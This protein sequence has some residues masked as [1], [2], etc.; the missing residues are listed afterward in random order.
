MKKAT[1]VATKAQKA[2][3]NSEKQNQVLSLAEATVMVQKAI[4]GSKCKA[5][6]DS[7]YYV[8]FGVKANGFSV[9]VKKTKYNVYCNDANLEVVEG[10]KLEGITI[11]R[12]GNSSDKTRPNAIETKSTEALEA[13]IKAVLSSVYTVAVDAN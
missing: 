6:T 2:V 4:I 7:K 5:F 12:N 10:L 13:M 11:T 8:G 9:N 3:A 1:E